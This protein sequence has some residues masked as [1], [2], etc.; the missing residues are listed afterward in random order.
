MIYRIDEKRNKP[1]GTKQA[2]RKI[3]AFSAIAHFCSFSS[4]TSVLVS[5]YIVN[6]QNWQLI[7]YLLERAF[8]FCVLISD[9]GEMLLQGCS[10]MLLEVKARASIKP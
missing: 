5:P 6:V 3:N 8:S 10:P 7:L 4:Y 9:I 2:R 1:K